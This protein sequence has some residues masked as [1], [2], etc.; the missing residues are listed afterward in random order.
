LPDERMYVKPNFYPGKPSVVPWAKRGE[1]VVLQAGSLPKKGIKSLLHAW[2]LW[3]A[4]SPLLQLVGDGEMRKELEEMSA[5]LPI[6]FLGQVSSTEAQAHIANA[7]LLVLP[8]ECFEGFPMVIRE[9]FAFGTP[10]AVSNIGPLPSIVQHGKNGIVFEPENPQSLLTAV[11]TAWESP[12]L[13]EKLGTGAR[14]EFE[15]KY[16]EDV[17]Y[18]ILMD[19]YERAIHDM[20]RER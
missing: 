8:S 20:K 1:Y 5:G 17:N 6:K 12:Y 11:R 15:S 7:R 3:G 2:K 9:A 16:T 4:N 18:K 19:I 14:A 13:L 10:I